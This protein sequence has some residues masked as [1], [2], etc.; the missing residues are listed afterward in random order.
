MTVTDMRRPSTRRRSQRGQTLITFALVAVVLFAVIGMAVDGGFS[1]FTSDKLERGAMSAALAGV[2]NMPDFNVPPNDATSVATTAAAKNGW[3]AGGANNVAIKVAK[4]LD[5]SGQP[6]RNQLSV[7]ITSDVPVFFMKLL[8][9]SS[10]RESRTAVA[11]YLRPITFGQPGQQLG[12]TVDQLGT[13][14][15]YYFLRSEGWGTERGQGDAYGPNPLDW[16][17]AYKST[18]THA[19]NSIQNSEAP[20]GRQPPIGLPQRGGQNYQIY[21]PAGQ[22]AKLQVYNPAFA[23]DNSN[24]GA[25]GYNYHEDDNDFPETGTGCPNAAPRCGPITKQ[26]WPLMSYTVYQTSN[27]F[28]HTLDQWMSNL[29]IQSMDVTSRTTYTIPT[30]ATP[31]V[32]YPT[33][34]SGFYHQWVDVANP[35]A[36]GQDTPVSTLSKSTSYASVLTGAAG[37]GSL[38]RLRVDQLDS[39]TSPPDPQL[40]GRTNIQ[41]SQAHKGYS[42]ALAPNGTG[43]VATTPPAP[44]SGCSVTALD[45]ITIYTPII[46]GPGISGFTM[47]L[48]SI[49]PEYAGHSFSLFIFDPGDVGCS[50]PNQCSNVISVL[51]P[52]GAGTTAIADTTLGVFAGGPDESGAFGQVVPPGK[53]SIDTQN[54]AANP[55]NI[56]NGRWIRYDISV[57]RDYA[58]ADVTPSDASTWFWS[59]SYTTA[60]PAGDTITAN[61]GFSGAPVHLVNG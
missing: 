20:A 61:L 46:P 39:V 22:S 8:G 56:Y 42:V 29:I 31:N 17:G 12:S 6:L 55:S 49:P 24:P 21:I 16:G 23:P 4:V 7:T 37:T 48:V 25:K 44:P 13:S 50:K 51:R 36:T 30:G 11:E 35:P 52:N 32:T 10:H 3:A 38:Y 40:N 2:P 58:T 5:N 19:L 18:D 43:C 33:A 1:Y 47:P 53:A 15:Q 57:P 60:L 28:D 9:F 14:N 41:N 27:P 34:T 45:D 54:P 59:L 26:Q